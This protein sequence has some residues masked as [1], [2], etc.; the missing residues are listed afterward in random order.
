VTWGNVEGIRQNEEMKFGHGGRERLK[1]TYASRFAAITRICG[2]G[3]RIDWDS[4]I[5]LPDLDA[6]RCDQKSTFGGQPKGDLGLGHPASTVPWLNY[7][8]LCGPVEVTNRP[9]W[10]VPSL[11]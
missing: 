11:V 7:L 4:G 10:I 6:D 2:P 1:R 9:K 8:L 5:Y 3:R